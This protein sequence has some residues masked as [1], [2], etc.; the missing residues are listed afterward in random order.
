MFMSRFIIS[1]LPRGVSSLDPIVGWG[2]WIEPRIVTLKLVGG[3]F[4][5][6]CAQIRPLGNFQFY[7]G[8]TF[9]E[10]AMA[11]TSA[12]NGTP[13]VECLFRQ[14]ASAVCSMSSNVSALWA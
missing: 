12:G 7:P 10:D 2:S 14:V 9:P 8:A 6:S 4:D 1:R 11:E 3:L 13:I 5:Y